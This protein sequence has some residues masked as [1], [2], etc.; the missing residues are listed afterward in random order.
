MKTN[1]QMQCVGLDQ[2]LI[3]TNQQTFL[4]NEENLSMAQILDGIKELFLILLDMNGTVI[5][6]F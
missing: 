4:D 6:V 1:N 3:C 5:M 2:I